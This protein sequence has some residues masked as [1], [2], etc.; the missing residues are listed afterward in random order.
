MAEVDALNVT[1]AE[2]FGQRNHAFF[3]DNIHITTGSWMKDLKDLIDDK[4]RNDLTIALNA[5]EKPI[6]VAQFLI[7]QN[8]I[9]KYKRFINIWKKHDPA[10]AKQFENNLQNRID[11]QGLADVDNRYQIELQGIHTLILFY[12]DI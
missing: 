1:Y 9:L 3:R 2:A 11:N 8:S 12:N 5:N 10:K 7:K 4:C 6:I